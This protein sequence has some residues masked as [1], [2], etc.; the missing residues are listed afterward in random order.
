MVGGPATGGSSKAIEAVEDPGGHW[1]AYA[2]SRAY[3]S[4]VGQHFGQASVSWVFCVEVADGPQDFLACPQCAG[5]GEIHFEF[6]GT[7]TCGLCGG[8]GKVHQACASLARPAEPVR[9]PQ[10]NDAAVW[11]LI[12]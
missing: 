1:L 2:L 4:V 7:R 11:R 6:Y 9:S 5:E 3:D 8:H 10:E 12:S